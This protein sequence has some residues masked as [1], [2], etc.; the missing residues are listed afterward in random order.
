MRKGKF[1]TAT[2]IRHL[3][4]TGSIV[5]HRGN[6]LSP[7]SWKDTVGFDPDKL[8][9]AEHKGD[10]Q[11]GPDWINVALGIWSANLGK[12]FC[13]YLVLHDLNNNGEDLPFGWHLD[14]DRVPLC[15]QPESAIKRWIAV[16]GYS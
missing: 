7:K 9:F 3:V 6:V 5:S 4:F 10:S 11:E 13:Q 1:N 16:R 15:Y 14:F 8:F 12:M 2:G